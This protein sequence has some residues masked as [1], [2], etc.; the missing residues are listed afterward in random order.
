MATAP[1]HLSEPIHEPDKSQTRRHESRATEPPRVKIQETVTDSQ[2]PSYQV[3]AR[4][5]RA[6]D[7]APRGGRREGGGE[8]VRHAR[9]SRIGGGGEG[10]RR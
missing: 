8:G 1:I 10:K 2:R 9:R 4:S 6:A 7:L 5:P 3:K